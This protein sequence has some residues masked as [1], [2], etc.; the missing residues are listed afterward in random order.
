MTCIAYRNGILAADS[1]MTMGKWTETDKCQ[2][3]WK[4]SDGSL[5]GCAGSWYDIKALVAAVEESIK[6]K[7]GKRAKLPSGKFK[8]DVILVAPSGR[9]YVY[10]K[11]WSNDKYLSDFYAV[12]SGS[13]LAMAA[14]DAGA[15][16]VE[17][18]KIAIKRDICCG[19][20]IQKLELE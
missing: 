5:I 7:S 10:Y 19:G 1:R 3:L 20:K 17:A 12:G 13:T 16:A 6:N 9:V 18:V 15:S 14:M 4:L 2:K 11:G 8:A